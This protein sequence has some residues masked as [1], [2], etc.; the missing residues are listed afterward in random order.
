MTDA[1]QIGGYGRLCD[2][3]ARAQDEAAFFAAID[4]ARRALLGEGLLTVSAYDA[5][6]SWLERVW[7]SNPQAYPVGGGKHK[8]DT[9]WT[10]QVLHRGEVFVGEGDAAI[11]EAFDDHERIRGLG[12]HAVVNVPLLWRG[13]CIATFNVLRPQPRWAP[14]EIEHVRTLAQVSLAAMVA[15]RAR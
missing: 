2:V 5:P 11:A 10:R 15:R 9:P 3:L 12:L 7:S 6:R 1:A 14:R 4:A 13:A 8:G